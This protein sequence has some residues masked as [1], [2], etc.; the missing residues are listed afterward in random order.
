MN[1]I[2]I[3]M[4]DP[5]GVGPEIIL[6]LLNSLNSNQLN[7]LVIIGNSD[8]L[9]QANNLLGNKINFKKFNSQLEIIDL[10]SKFIEE[11]KP[12]KISR[13]GGEAAFRYFEKAIQMGLNNEISAIVTAPLCKK[14]LHNAGHLFDGH[15]EILKKLTNAHETY[16]LL[17]GGLLNTVHVSTHLSLLN[18]IKS[19]A[20]ERII[21]TIEIVN[22]H[23]IKMHQKKPLIAVPGLNPHSGENGIFGDEEQNKIIPAIEY[24]KK[25]SIK[26]FGP[27]SPDTVFFRALNGEFDV[28]VALYHDQGHIPTKLISFEE[29]VN[30]TLGTP[31]IRTSVDHGTAHEIAWEGKASCKN[32][33]AAINYAKKMIRFK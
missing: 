24:C 4:G 10:K 31:L 15:T 32:L 26:V 1:K 22:Q 25:K 20:T 29:S 18:A 2:A 17:T 28:V 5:S 7:E 3:T 14:A 27:I 8:I 16:M 6:S 12:K 33:L 13:G 30:V 9:N 19:L 11:V 21:K 23:F